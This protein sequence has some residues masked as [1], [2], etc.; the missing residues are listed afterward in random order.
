M[1][2]RAEFDWDLSVEEENKKRKE[3]LEMLLGYLNRDLTP[4]EKEYIE[5]GYYNDYEE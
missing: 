1:L 2:W 3:Y 5:D 4:K